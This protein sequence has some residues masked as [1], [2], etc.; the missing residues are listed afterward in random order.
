M[1]RE[2]PQVAHANTE[3][4]GTLISAER[5]KRF[6]CIDIRA[7]VRDGR[8]RANII[9]LS[10]IL[11]CQT[12]LASDL[13][14]HYSLGVPIFISGRLTCEISGNLIVPDC[15]KRCPDQCYTGNVL[16]S[17]SYQIWPLGW[18]HNAPLSAHAA[19]NK[20]TPV[21]RKRTLE[22]PQACQ[23]ISYVD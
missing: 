2:Q 4:A 15:L 16:I 14:G 10:K 8:D 21:T 22:F 3:V 5:S 1:E 6:I 9:V 11:S 7:A 23:L 18:P 17:M 13:R 19:R 12:P 20:E